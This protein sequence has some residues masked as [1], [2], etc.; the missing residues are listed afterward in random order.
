MKITTRDFGEITIDQEDIVKFPG[1][2]PG[3]QDKKEFALIPLT[4]NS[5]FTIMQSVNEPY[6]AF[7]ILQ[8]GLYLDNYQFKIDS[9]TSQKLKITKKEQVLTFN[10]ATLGEKLTEMTV[11]LAA[12][13]IIN[14][15]KKLGKQLILDQDK[16]AIQFPLFS[17]KKQLAKVVR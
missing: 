10:I 2:I 12:P 14:N 6:L 11:N 17:P 15:Q 16:Y 13:L 5:P 1:G 7:I 3:F 8:A 4:K 9:K